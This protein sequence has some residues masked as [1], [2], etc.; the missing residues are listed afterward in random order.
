MEAFYGNVSEGFLKEDLADNLEDVSKTFK[1]K[2][3]RGI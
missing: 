2:F 3:C 1:E